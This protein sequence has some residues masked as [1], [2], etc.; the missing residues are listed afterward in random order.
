VS[1]NEGKIKGGN[2]LNLIV[3][4]AMV[5]E[6]SKNR[7]KRAA[8]ESEVVDLAL[9]SD[10]RA[11][12]IEIYQNADYNNIGAVDKLD[13][14]A[15]PGFGMEGAGEILCELD[16]G[17]DNLVTKKEFLAFM[18]RIKIQYST[19]GD[20]DSF[21]NE[22]LGAM[23]QDIDSADMIVEE[24]TKTKRKGG[25]LSHDGT[26]LEV[27]R[28]LGII[29]E[30]EEAQVLDLSSRGRKRRFSNLL[31]HSIGLMLMLMSY[32][33]DVWSEEVCNAVKID[34]GLSDSDYGE[35]TKDSVMCSFLFYIVTFLSACFMLQGS[36]VTGY[37]NKQVCLA[38]TF[39]SFVA[40]I[41]G[42]IG[43]YYFW[44]RLMLQCPNSCVYVQTSGGTATAIPT[45]SISSNWIYMF[46]ALIILLPAPCLFYSQAKN[47]I[48]GHGIRFPTHT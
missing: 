26:P 24:E 38:S 45:C 47:S 42:F 33:G 34:R 21:M 30:D 31:L 29:M 23:Q 14:I 25:L 43:C 10:Q 15:C 11:K 4:A 27:A 46:V 44:H 8:R 1:Q 39:F 28:E 40:S 5:Q 18:T 41:V 7:K 13:I 17:S 35:N 20:E 6:R 19:N 32:S 12:V 36:K 16:A 2:V 48:Q 22:M 3:R 9:T 37:C